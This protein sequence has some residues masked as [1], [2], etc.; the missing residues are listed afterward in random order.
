LGPW[1]SQFSFEPLDSQNCKSRH[2]WLYVIAWTTVIISVLPFLDQF[3]KFTGVTLRH[4]SQHND[5][6]HN[7]TQHKGLISDIQHNNDLPLCYAECGILFMIMLKVIMLRVVMLN[8]VLLSVIML[9]VV[10]PFLK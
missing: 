5:I 4:D 6:Q 10:A 9:S 1:A 8:V 2:G 7:D 3:A